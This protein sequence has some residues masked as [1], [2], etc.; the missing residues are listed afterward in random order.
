[1]KNINAATSSYKRKN[2]EDNLKRSYAEALQN[3]EFKKLIN[4]LKITEDIAIKYTSK[5]EET[6][7][8]LELCSKCKSL[9]ECKNKVQ[10]YIYYPRVV[11][12]RLEFDY[13]PCKHM[14]KELKET[15]SIKSDV[16]SLPLEIKKARMKDI[17]QDD[18]KRV[19]II[20]WLTDFYKNYQ[21]DPHIK[22]LYLYGSFGSGKT[23]M[24]SAL[25]NELSKE[26]YGVVI[27]YYPELLR[28]LKESFENNDFSSKI[29]NITT[30]KLLMLDDIGAETVTSWNRDEILG[31]ILQYRMDN[32]L[33][34]FFTSNLTLK[35]LENHFNVRNTS[36]EAIKAR[37]IIERIKQI[38]DYQELIS[39]N[40]RK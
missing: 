30:A 40:R 38:T 29:N 14:K 24:V 31:T 4:T 22:G 28:S 33:P 9:H 8:E 27:V 36:E 18:A 26:T 32:K 20:K 7:K 13:V 15:E 6:V 37:R 25:L 39:E 19:K 1:M 21:K 10:G 5:L 2:I 16:F 34:T 12:D 23:Y 3:Q 17:H 11:E 35:E